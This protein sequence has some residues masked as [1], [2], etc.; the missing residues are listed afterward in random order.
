MRLNLANFMKNSI[1]FAPSEAP[2]Y[3]AKRKVLGSAFSKSKLKDI[4][5]CVKEITIKEI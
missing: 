2:D 3:E 1:V 5:Q 4:T